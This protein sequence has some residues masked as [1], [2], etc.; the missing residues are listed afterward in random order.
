MNTEK[1]LKTSLKGPI[2]LIISPIASLVL[3]II[4]FAMVNFI[5][6]GMTS[7]TISSDSSSIGEGALVAGDETPDSLF[8]EEYANSSLFKTT[9]NVILFLVGIYG[10]A[11]FIPCLV[12]GIIMINNRLDNRRVLENRAVQTDTLSE[13]HLNTEERTQDI[14]GNKS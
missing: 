2:I 12:V 14:S 3:A 11:G 1:P 9:S 6:S 8:A 5:F 10:V 7:D 13:L 4:M